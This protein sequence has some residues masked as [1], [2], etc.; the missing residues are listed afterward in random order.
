V[1]SSIAAAQETRKKGGAE[2][3]RR[4]PFD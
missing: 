3:L 4:I 2:E 1:P